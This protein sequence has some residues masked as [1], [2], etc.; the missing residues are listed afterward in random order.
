MT[1][2][3]EP[4]PIAEWDAGVVKNPLGNSAHSLPGCPPI[5]ANYVRF[6][7]EKFSWEP[8]LPSPYS[9][10]IAAESS[11]HC[12]APARIAKCCGQLCS[13]NE[14]TLQANKN[15][16]LMISAD[17]E[18]SLRKGFVLAI[19]WLICLR[20][21]IESGHWSSQL[22][23]LRPGTSGCNSAE[24]LQSFATRANRTA[25]PSTMKPDTANA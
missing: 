4:Q 12:P 6:A 9:D 18:T 22:G 8:N 3:E 15:L 2:H 14:M 7:S 16:V 11:W 20:R 24:D 10:C 23:R 1:P 21:P 5:I 25:P 13:A 19:F 17:Y